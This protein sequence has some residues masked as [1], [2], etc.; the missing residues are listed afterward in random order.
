ERTL[1]ARETRS[2]LSTVLLLAL[3]GGAALLLRS[4]AVQ[5][6]RVLSSSML[7]LLEPGDY[8]LAKRGSRWSPQALPKRGSVVVFRRASA[9]GN[10]EL[11]K[12]VIGLP[13]DV[14]AA[15]NGFPVINGWEIPHCDAGRYTEITPQGAT[16]GRLLVEF[17]DDRAYLAVYTPLTRAAPEYTV[18]PDEVFVLGDNRNESMDSRFWNDGKA[19]GLALSD[20]DGEITRRLSDV[21]RDMTP[22]F[23][24]FLQ[25]LDLIVRIPG[26]DSSRLQEGI[27]RCLA[28][29]PSQTHPPETSVVR[30]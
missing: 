21:R 19:S 23:G 17:L 7:P 5:I 11:I 14:I 28:S 30:Q 3:V 9:Q 25:P 6:C 8:L 24:R 13:G 2:L 4:H 22:T 15:P 1:R 26:V 20:I 27:E 18:K 10:D 16:D 12:R 29:P